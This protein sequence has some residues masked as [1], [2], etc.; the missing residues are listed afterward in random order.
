L[1]IPY[2]YRKELGLEKEDMLST[3]SDLKIVTPGGIFKAFQ[4][5]YRIAEG[6]S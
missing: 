2:E 6:A 4:K 5:I 1:T 3:R